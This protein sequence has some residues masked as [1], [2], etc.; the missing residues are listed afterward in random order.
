ME[1][2]EPA[3]DLALVLARNLGRPAG[4]GKSRG[5]GLCEG[6]RST[7]DDEEERKRKELLVRA[8]VRAFRRC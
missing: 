8:S 1:D 4:V 3:L 2:R 5:W 6:G 7:E